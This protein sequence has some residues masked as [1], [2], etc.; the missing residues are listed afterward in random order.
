MRTFCLLLATAA[1]ASGPA[2]QTVTL[3][4]PPFT[5][6]EEA[7]PLA[8]APSRYQQWFSATDL[9]AAARLPIRIRRMA[10]LAGI[11][12]QPGSTV[13]LEIRMA[14][15]PFGQIPST[16]FDNNLTRDNTVVVPRGVYSLALQ[17]A[18]DTRVITFTFPR[19]FA[20]DGTSGIVIDIKVYG[21][22]NN[23]QSYLYPCRASFSSGGKLTRLYAVGNPANLTRATTLQTGA[24]LVT[25]FDYVDGA[26]VSFGAGCP[27]AG[28]QVPVA[29]TSGGLPIPPNPGWT[30]TLN[31]VAP[32]APTALVVGGSRTTFGGGA[33][34]FDLGLIGFPG[35]LLRVDPLVFFAAT[36]SAGGVA[37]VPMPLPGVTLRRR[38]IFVQWFVFDRLAPNGAL[39][40]SQGMWHVF[41]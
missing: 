24:G 37:L 25:E 12:R 28:G 4:T 41:G 17:P 30:Q 13:D 29:G 35:C 36:S 39:A 20:W 6:S 26:S 8:T 22:G 16:T 11:V 38:Y 23:N 27:G 19:E 14:H 3:P 1:V 5:P 2:A 32:L 7:L 33:L 10:F 18:P 34:P 21:N 9:A 31:S 15:L 40:A